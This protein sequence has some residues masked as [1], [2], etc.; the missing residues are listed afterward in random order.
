M[1]LNERIFYLLERQKKT[2]KELGEYIGV[3]PSSIS[4]WKNEGSFPSSKYIVRISE[5]FNVSLDFLCTGSERSTK[6]LP[7]DQQELINIYNELDS[8]GKHRL[9]T[10][11]YEELDRIENQKK[12]DPKVQPKYIA[13]TNGENNNDVIA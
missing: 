9:H 3:K 13:S 4:G 8:R 2:A 10:I 7:A 1:M 6:E 12:K 11:I 5:F